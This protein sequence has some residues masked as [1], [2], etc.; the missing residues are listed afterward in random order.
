MR[1][2]RASDAAALRRRPRGTGRRAGIRRARRGPRYRR[3]QLGSRDQG[4]RDRARY[5]APQARE[6][7][8]AAQDRTRRGGVD[9][10]LRDGG[11]L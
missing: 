1:S 10:A 11:G 3:G 8:R 7:R 2:G 9:G 6:A 4:V 5:R